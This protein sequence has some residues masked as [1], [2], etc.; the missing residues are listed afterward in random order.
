MAQREILLPWDSQPQETTGLG[1]SIPPPSL[2]WS[3]AFPDNDLAGSAAITVGAA[4]TC[5]VADVGRIVTTAASSTGFVTLGAV[6][7]A[8]WT[9]PFTIAIL[10]R[11][12]TLNSFIL[13]SRTGTGTG[14]HGVEIVHG[15]SAGDVFFRMNSAGSIRTSSTVS[16]YND[17]KFHLFM[18]GR[19]ADET[20]WAWIDG[21]EVSANIGVCTGTLTSGNPLTPGR[22][23]TTYGAH[24]YGLGAVW[25]GLSFSDQQRRAIAENLWAA[26]FAPQSIWVPFSAGGGGGATLLPSSITSLEAFGTASISVGPVSVLVSGISSSEAFGTHVISNG[27]VIIIP[28]GIASLEAFG[29]AI[30]DRGTVIVAPS[31]IASAEAFGTGSVLV[32]ELVIYPNGISSAELFGIPTITGGTPST[33]TSVFYVRGFSSFGFR[34]N[35]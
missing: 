19:N 14:A 15:A 28:S 29:T 24:E 11:P 6:A 10:A 34:R 2:L 25:S 20:A 27:S 35:S 9:G 16:G 33:I 31:G 8:T 7:D 13:S 4:A 18:V 3:G 30:L 17:G 21:V 23:A 32:G 26:L 12:S 1:G 22:R 5:G